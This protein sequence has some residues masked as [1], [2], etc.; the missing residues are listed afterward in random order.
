VALAV[1]RLGPDEVVADVG[2]RAVD[3]GIRRAE[4]RSPGYLPPAETTYV[5]VV[6]FSRGGTWAA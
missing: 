5:F 3:L 1:L 4:E 6:R 2:H